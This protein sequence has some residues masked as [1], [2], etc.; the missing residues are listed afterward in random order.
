M[1]ALDKIIALILEK[2]EERCVRC[3]GGG[4][5]MDEIKID[6]RAIYREVLEENR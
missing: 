3:G 1:S 4:E 2:H 6:A 5:C